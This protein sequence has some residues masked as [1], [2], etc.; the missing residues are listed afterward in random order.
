[1]ILRNELF[2]QPLLRH[3]MQVA[4]T[5]PP[6][7]LEEISCLA[8]IIC[9]SGDS[10]HDPGLDEKSKKREIINDSRT[11]YGRELSHLPEH[12][13]RAC[14]GL[15]SFTNGK[16]MIE[17]SVETWSDVSK[18]ARA[19]MGTRP[20][21]LHTSRTKTSTPGRGERT[22]RQD[23]SIGSGREQETACRDQE[24]FLP[25]LSTLHPQRPTDEGGEQD[26]RRT[27]LL[28]MRKECD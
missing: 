15:I 14:F 10:G 17:H 18:E 26:R 20:A 8:G 23:T 24:T 6:L 16:I 9:E 12:E 13:I 25:G 11:N 28:Q 2:P 19:S 4:K 5:P 22:P 21:K 1:M 3:E 7:F 27:R